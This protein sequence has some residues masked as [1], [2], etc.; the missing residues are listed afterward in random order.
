MPRNPNWSRDELI[1]ALDLY[2]T[3]GRRQLP[4][5]DPAIIEL[6]A[7]LNRLPVHAAA[8]KGAEFRNPNGVSMKLG[9]FLRVDPDWA[10]AGL[11]RGNRLEQVV[12]DEFANDVYR[13]RS[14]AAAIRRSV[15]TGQVAEPEQDYGD[16]DDEEVFPEGRLLTR[17]HR[18]RERNRRAV[19]R[20]KQQVLRATGAL[21]CEVC[22]FDFEAVYGPLAKPFAECH[23]RLPLASLPAEDGRETRPRDLA[24]VCAN[25]HRMLHALRPVPTVEELRARVAAR[26]GAPG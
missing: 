15:E 23:H 18:Q 25:C 14:T 19:E 12:W 26:R 5:N 1:L 22:G 13:L 20:K 9:N 21:R 17:M 10:G 2:I 8:E 4:A 3:A 11:Q 16:G 24:V 7:L 6:S